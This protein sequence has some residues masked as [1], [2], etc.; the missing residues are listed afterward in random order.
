MELQFRTPPREVAQLFR[1]FC[2]TMCGE[3]RY[4]KRMF[5]AA[6]HHHH[7]AHS[8]SAAVLAELA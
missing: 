6:H 4:R 5:R 8:A 7:H 1:L 3:F 2:L